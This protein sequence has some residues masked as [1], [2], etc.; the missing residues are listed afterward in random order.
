MPDT[1]A[2]KIESWVKTLSTTVGAPNS[3]TY[4][5]GHS[6]GCQ[7]ILRYLCA[8]EADQTFGGAV[9]V[10]PWLS[11]RADSPQEP[12]DDEVA[13][14]WLIN[15]PDLNI[16]RSHLGGTV[17]IFSDNDYYVD[18]DREQ[19]VFAQQLGA[20]TIMLHDRGHIFGQDGVTELPEALE[21]ILDLAGSK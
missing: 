2:P 1:D 5:V 9:L 18:S 4:L 16:A 20:Q 21:S 10:A 12:G 11:L 17:A 19:P 7:T 15:L 14:P 13:P 8:L 6:I 3:N